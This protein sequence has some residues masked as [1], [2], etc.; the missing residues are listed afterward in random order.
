MYDDATNAPSP[1][2]VRVL[3]MLSCLAMAC[4][5]GWRGAMFD[6]PNGAYSAAMPFVMCQLSA[7]MLCVVGLFSLDGSR[8][9][10]PA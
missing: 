2:W 10:G 5:V 1:L 6:D 8:Q 9:T 4:V 3:R 7:I